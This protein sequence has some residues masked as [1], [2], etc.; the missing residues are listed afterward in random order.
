MCEHCGQKLEIGRVR[1]KPDGK[2]KGL[3]EADDARHCGFCKMN[4]P[5]C[6]KGLH[7]V[8]R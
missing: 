6:A 5:C 2:N 3:R 7:G 8:V 1:E 4:F